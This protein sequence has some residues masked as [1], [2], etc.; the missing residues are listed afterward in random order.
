M[1]S[2]AAIVA[3]IYV[4]LIL[5]SI[6][7]VIVAVLARRGRFKFWVGIAMNTLTGLVAAWAVTATLALGLVP[8]LGLVAGSIV[9]TWPKKKS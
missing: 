4:A 6:A 1:E 3:T 9:L 8:L 7:N 5:L 2:L